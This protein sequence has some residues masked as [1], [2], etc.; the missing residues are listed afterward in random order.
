MN[1]RSIIELDNVDE[2]KN[3]IAKG[4]DVNKALWHGRTILWYATHQKSIECVNALIDA[5]ADVNKADSDGSTPLHIDTI[6]LP[7]TRC[8]L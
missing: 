3:W 6:M 1:L 8:L 4:A 2:L 5:K 7:I